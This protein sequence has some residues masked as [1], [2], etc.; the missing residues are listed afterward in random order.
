MKFLA[1]AEQL[2]I[3]TSQIKLRLVMDFNPFFSLLGFWGGVGG[4]GTVFLVVV[5]TQRHCCKE[6]GGKDDADG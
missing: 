3:R 1:L 4:L 2:C 5:L 6:D